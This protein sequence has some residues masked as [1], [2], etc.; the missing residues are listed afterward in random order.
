MIKNQLDQ[1][2]SA[3]VEP[4]YEKKNDVAKKPIWPKTPSFQPN[5]LLATADALLRLIRKR[6]PPVTSYCMTS[7]GI[8]NHLITDTKASGDRNRLHQFGGL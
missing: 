5:H 3:V 2:I 1:N 6:D 7:H 8:S 4:V